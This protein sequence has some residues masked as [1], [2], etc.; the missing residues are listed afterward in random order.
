VSGALDRVIEALVWVSEDEVAAAPAAAGVS[1]PRPSASA[2]LFRTPRPGLE[3]SPHVVFE[4]EW[5]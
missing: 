2:A 3:T 1:V 5:V 4:V